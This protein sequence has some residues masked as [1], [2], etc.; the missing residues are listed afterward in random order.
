MQQKIRLKRGDTFAQTIALPSSYFANEAEAVDDTTKAV[1][2]RSNADYQT[3]LFVDNSFV[4]TNQSWDGASNGLT[5]FDVRKN[6]TSAWPAKNLQFT[7]SFT[8]AEGI[9]YSSLPLI[10]DVRA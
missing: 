6:D 7:F 8:N 10:V 5:I 4:I 9:K 2:V 3:V 1:E